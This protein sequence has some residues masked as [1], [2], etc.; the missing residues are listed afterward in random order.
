MDFIFPEV[1]KN[2][3]IYLS[4]HPLPLSVA[5]TFSNI[6]N[7]LSSFIFLEP[8][9]TRL[10]SLQFRCRAIILYKIYSWIL[11]LPFL[12]HPFV[13]LEYI[14]ECLCHNGCPKGKK[15]SGF[16]NNL[17]SHRVDNFVAYVIG[18]CKSLTSELRRHSSLF[19]DMG[20]VGIPRAV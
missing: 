15:K 13:W 12:V 11:S 16:L 1:L 3:S 4:S 2:L 10:I 9:G 18:G 19:C 8:F 17:S 6:Q 7:I 5:R 20:L 14:L